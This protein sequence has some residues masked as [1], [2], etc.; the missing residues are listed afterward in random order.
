MS[1]ETSFSTSDALPVVEDLNDI[2][3]LFSMMGT[4]GIG[5]LEIGTLKI[6]RQ[7]DIA[8]TLGND[9]GVPDRPQPR[10]IHE[11][12]FLYSDGSVPSFG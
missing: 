12:P 10:P 6:V 11:D 8:K 4:Y 7:P 5:I 1:S 3:R 9:K 2:E